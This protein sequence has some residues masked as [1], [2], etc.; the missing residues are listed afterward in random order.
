MS[1]LE[2]TRYTR[3][4]DE[5]LPFGQVAMNQS[6]SDTQ[7]LNPFWVVDLIITVIYMLELCLTLIVKFWRPFLHDGW[8][9]FDL[10]CVLFSVIGLVTDSSVQ[11]VRLVRI[12]RVV[13]V[14]HRAHSES[15]PKCTGRCL[16]C[17]AARQRLTLLH[18]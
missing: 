6:S 12:L 13:S 16:S 4:I 5:V 14:L 1:S 8:C 17:S 11:V 3:P 18:L 10:F 7:A 15:M 9:H 2:L